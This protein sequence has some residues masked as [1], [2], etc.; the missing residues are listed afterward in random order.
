MKILY[1]VQGTGNGHITRSR[2]V[3]SELRKRG[4]SV[5]VLISGR[6][7]EKLFDLEDIEPYSINK[8]IT[9]CTFKGKIDIVRSAINLNLFEFFND[10][11]K[12]KIKE[13]DIVI[14][15]FEPISAWVAKKNRKLS[16]GLA[17]QYAFAHKIPI[18]GDN[19][20]TRLVLNYF[21]PADIKI[22]MHY[23]HFNQP[24]VPPVI[25]SFDIPKNL[26]IKKNKVLV[27][28]PFEDLKD[29]VEFLKPFDKYLFTIYHDIKTE[30]RTNNIYV[31]PF[32]KINFKKDLLSS[33]KVLSS[34]GF[35]LPSEVLSLGKGLLLK[36]VLGQ[37]EQLS[38][39]CAIKNLGL[40]LSMEQFNN[41]IMRDW[42]SL[43]NQ[44]PIN[45]PLS[46]PIL[47]DWIS[48]KKWD[49]LD[50]LVDELWAGVK[51]PN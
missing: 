10:V 8:G 51:F 1:G 46:A 35:E 30:I 25:P 26:K 18:D 12:K 9:F 29:I 48:Q 6:P 21:A 20:F 13:I 7:K 24:I 17:H 34:A 41:D 40:G 39:V 37:M 23:H 2:I 49:K 15:D 43:K 14:S 28:L 27:Y 16:I 11:I 50:L 22:G 36:P 5:E 4:H 32:S 38:N 47:A 42:L 19:I 31:K 44:N 45:Y 33:D 3:I